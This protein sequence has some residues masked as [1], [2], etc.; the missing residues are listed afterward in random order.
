M[1]VNKLWADTVAR[2]RQEGERLTKHS[3][4]SDYDYYDA[5]PRDAIPRECAK[6]G[7]QAW[8]S[9][10]EPYQVQ[11]FCERPECKAAALYRDGWSTNEL[12]EAEEGKASGSDAVCLRNTV[13]RSL[14]T[15]DREW[16]GL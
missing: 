6:C 2:A 13:A 12:G 4:P 3:A 16:E 8:A 7:G 11:V 1:D 10:S 15:A 9:I 14:P 5:G